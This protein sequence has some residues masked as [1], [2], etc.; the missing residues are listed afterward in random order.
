MS[1]RDRVEAQWY[2]RATWLLVL[3]PL[4]Y[5]LSVLIPIR[6][7]RLQA[8]AQQLGIPVIVVGNISV[9]GT[10]K[11]PLIAALCQQLQKQGFSPGI[12]S[13]GYGSELETSTLL[14]HDASPETFGDEPVML[15]K[16][17]GCPVVVGPHR[18]D[19]IQLLKERLQCDVILSDDGLQHYQMHRDIEIAVIDAQKGF[20]NGWLLPVGPLREQPE[21]SLIHI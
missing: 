14:P 4:S 20:G 12:I 17:T 13:R 1:L 3:A 18:N 6:R 10:G 19:S 21:L 15:A 7:R 8:R 2:G 16:D 9:G 5:L 11:T